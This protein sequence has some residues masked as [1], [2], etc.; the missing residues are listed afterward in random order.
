VSRFCARQA[1]PASRPLAAPPIDT[2]PARTRRLRLAQPPRRHRTIRI[3]RP[4]TDRHTD[5]I[6]LTTPPPRPN[7]RAPHVH[8]RIHHPPRIQRPPDIPRPRRIH[9]P[10][11]RPR[12]VAALRRPHHHLI[13]LPPIHRP[14]RPLIPR[15]NAPHHQHQ[16]DQASAHPPTILA[17]PPALSPSPARPAPPASAPSPPQVG[18]AHAHPLPPGRPPPFAVGPTKRAKHERSAVGVGAEEDFRSGRELEAPGEASAP[19]QRRRGPRRPPRPTSSGLASARCENLRSPHPQ[20]SPPSAAR[21]PRSSQAP[22]PNTPPRAQPALPDIPPSR[23]ESTHVPLTRNES[24]LI[25]TS[26]TP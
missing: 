6:L 20:H 8:R 4:R 26:K 19:R 17:L 21:P 15:L 2:E 9:R 5:P 14:H 25:Y 22:T 12:P 3:P 10:P 13:R 23:Q 1:A 18:A 11:I 7:I 24:M 16:S